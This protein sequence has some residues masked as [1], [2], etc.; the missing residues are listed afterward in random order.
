MLCR[1]CSVSCPL[2]PG[3]PEPKIVAR[4]TALAPCVLCQSVTS[5][6]GLWRPQNLSIASGRLPAAQLPSSNLTAPKHNWH[7]TFFNIDPAPSFLRSSLNPSSCIPVSFTLSPTNHCRQR[8]EAPGLNEVDTSPAVQ[9]SRT[10]LSLFSHR[11]R[12]RRSSEQC[13]LPSMLPNPA[14]IRKLPLSCACAFVGKKL[15]ST[16]TTPSC[17]P[18]LRASTEM[19]DPHTTPDT[20]P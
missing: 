6:G 8:H 14:P 1:E 11:H 4:L 18:P 9:A 13:F 5:P 19:H 17:S 7:S 12:P 3:A 16:A 15:E 10:G 2:G 20:I